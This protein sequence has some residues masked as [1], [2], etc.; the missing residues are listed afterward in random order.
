MNDST[1]RLL[2][3]REVATYLSVSEHTVRRLVTRRRLPCLRVGRQLRF[4][5][6]VLSRWLSARREG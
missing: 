5:P 4:A 1:D 3:I 6:D 2:T